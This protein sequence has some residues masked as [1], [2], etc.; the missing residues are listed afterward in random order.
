MPVMINREKG[1]SSGYWDHEIAEFDLGSATV[2]FKSYFDWNQLDRVDF[3]FYQGV[4]LKS[5]KYPD[6]AGHELLVDNLYGKL[7]Y[8]DIP[9]KV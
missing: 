2:A 4:I 5:D 6:I 8:D 3:R 1:K 7:E 9:G